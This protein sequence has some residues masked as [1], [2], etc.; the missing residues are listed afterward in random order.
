MDKIE[1]WTIG[2]VDYV[3]AAVATVG[4]RLQTKRQ[5]L[6]NKV[7]IP[8]VQYYLPEIDGSP[9][10]PPD[11]HQFYQELIGMLQQATEIGHVDKEKIGCVDVL[12]E[13]S[14]MSQ[15]QASPWEGNLEQVL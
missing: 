14:L 8:M 12:H 13:T 3:Q 2:I 6:P 15:Y 5:K 4:E 1:C 10:L 11:D 7:T 9:E